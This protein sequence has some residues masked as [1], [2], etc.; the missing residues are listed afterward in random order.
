MG[1]LPSAWS[2]GNYLQS[3]KADAPVNPV[4][5]TFV[6]PQT[7]TMY[8]KP[9]L[10]TGP[11]KEKEMSGTGS[12]LGDATQRR[13]L[14]RS[15]F[16]LFILFGVMLLSIQAGALTSPAGAVTLNHIHE[17]EEQL[18]VP[19]APITGTIHM[20]IADKAWWGDACYSS[21]FDIKFTGEVEV[22]ELGVPAV[23]Q[24][25]GT[26]DFYCF[27]SWCSGCGQ[28]KYVFEDFELL[29]MTLLENGTVE[30]TPSFTEM[31]RYGGGNKVC[32]DTGIT[33]LSASWTETSMEFGHRLNFNCMSETILMRGTVTFTD[34]EGKP[35]T[36]K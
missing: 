27:T 6:G 5:G 26:F 24:A 15:P 19:G 14:A 29:P 4:L 17:G 10:G 36:I 23:V 16:T 13:T 20:E 12:K 3:E 25:P 9:C 28:I 31:R 30:Y 32:A 1:A 11:E 33:E 35:V 18:M 22:N 21:T 7:W 8:S 34:G 2:E